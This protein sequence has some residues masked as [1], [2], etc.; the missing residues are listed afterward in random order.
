MGL[1]QIQTDRFVISASPKS[2]MQ[3]ITRL[4]I[5]RHI[6]KVL[7][8]SDRQVLCCIGSV[9]VNLGR[10]DGKNSYVQSMDTPLSN[11]QGSKSWCI[12]QNTG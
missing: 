2:S 11:Q 1:V 8:S 6:F 7:G 4:C 9:A 10:E 3:V 12:D 5:S